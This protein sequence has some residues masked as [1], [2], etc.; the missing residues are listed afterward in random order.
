MTGTGAQRSAPSFAECPVPAMAREGQ[1]WPFFDNLTEPSVP[2]VLGK[3][4]SA[5]GWPARRP[6]MLRL[7]TTI[8]RIGLIT[9]LLGQCGGPPAFSSVM[10]ND[11]KR[12]NNAVLR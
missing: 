11:W 12:S 1:Y 2:I 3:A 4:A 9:L 8:V 7:A 5:M 6:L 10:S